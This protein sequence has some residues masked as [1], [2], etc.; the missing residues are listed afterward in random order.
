MD[1]SVCPHSLLERN[2]SISVSTHGGTLPNGSVVE[3]LEAIGFLCRPCVVCSGHANFV[4]RAALCSEDFVQ[5]S[6]ILLW[7]R[8]DTQPASI[9]AEGQEIWYQ[10]HCD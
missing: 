2:P 7:R 4:K 5:R 10:V 8:D 9:G 3:F 6:S 1:D